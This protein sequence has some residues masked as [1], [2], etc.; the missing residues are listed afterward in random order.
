MGCWNPFFGGHFPVVKFKV[1]PPWVRK[2]ERSD[3]FYVTDMS[4]RPSKLVRN[5]IPATN[6]SHFLSSKLTA[7]VANQNIFSIQSNDVGGT[8]CGLQ[9]GSFIHNL[10]DESI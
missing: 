6:E 7:S 3:L 8:S 1:F 5:S 9:T 2:T 4:T 10:V